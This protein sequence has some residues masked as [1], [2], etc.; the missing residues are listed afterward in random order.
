MRVAALGNVLLHG[1]VVAI[2]N[3]SRERD[4]WQVWIRTQALFRLML[5]NDSKSIKP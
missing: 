2:D 3:V 4:I 5:E 1:K